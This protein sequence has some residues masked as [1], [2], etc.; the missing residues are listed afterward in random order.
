MVLDP[1]QARHFSSSYLL[2]DHFLS[3]IAPSGTASEAE[4]LPLNTPS[5]EIVDQA[6][7]IN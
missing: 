3:K 7:L 4:N 2:L 5:K 6:C 1:R